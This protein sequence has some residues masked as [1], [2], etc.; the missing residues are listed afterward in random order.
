MSS[1]GMHLCTICG[2]QRTADERWFLVTENQWEDKLKVLRWNE[3]LASRG[4]V[5]GVC[6]PPHVRELVVHWMTTGMAPGSTA[7]GTAAATEHA[8]APED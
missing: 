4:G 6:S 3:R 7:N 2:G 1:A 8:P 5:H